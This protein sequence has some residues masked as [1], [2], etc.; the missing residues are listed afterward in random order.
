MDREEQKY[1]KIGF[2]LRSIYDAIGEGIADLEDLQRMFFKALPDMP[3]NV[4]EDVIVLLKKGADTKAMRKFVSVLIPTS[5]DLERRKA[6]TSAFVSGIT[7]Q[8]PSEITINIDE[9]DMEREADAEYASALNLTERQYEFEPTVTD[10]GL[11]DAAWEKYKETGDADALLTALETVDFTDQTA[12][13]PGYTFGERYASGMLQYYGLQDDLQLINYK[14]AAKNQNLVPVFNFGI[15]SSFLAGLEPGRIANIQDKLMRAGFLQPGSYVLGT[16][17]EIGTA[18]EDATVEALESA[19]SYLNT[20]PEYGLDVNDLR[21]IN[22][23]SGGEEGVFLGFMRNYFEEIIEEVQLRDTNP[24][25]TAPALIAQA[26][27]EFIKFNVNQTVRETIGANPSMRDYQVI[28]DWANGEIERLGA[29]Y[30]ESRRVYEQARVDMASQAYQDQVAGTQQ[31][32]Y[33]LPPAMSDDD[34]SSA[35]ATGLDEFVYNYFRPLIDEGKE[36]QAYQQGLGVAIA[37]LSR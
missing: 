30:V 9:S 19:F 14:E 12:A 8:D 3:K 7:G 15:A 6:L 37:S 10:R 33:L 25:I 13:G 22:L 35:F 17:G 4:V 11:A 16:I 27:P 28:A 31:D 18:G 26:N 21:E 5:E 29:A 36:A 2:T 34:V 24:I 1:Q 32:Y 23:L 20:K